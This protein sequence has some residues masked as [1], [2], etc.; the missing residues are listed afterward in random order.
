MQLARR[1]CAAPSE[2][3]GVPAVRGGRQ[4]LMAWVVPQNERMSALSDQPARWTRSGQVEGATAP[5]VGAASIAR[6]HQSEE[7]VLATGGRRI[8][9]KSSRLIASQPSVSE[10][11]A[12]SP[13]QGE[14]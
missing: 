10:Q 1:N 12:D 4:R 2:D 5:G 13:E 9:R 6:R 11:A 7:P 14:L 8:S 3:H